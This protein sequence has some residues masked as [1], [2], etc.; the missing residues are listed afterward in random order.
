MDTI[1]A[2]VALFHI[3][4]HP[5]ALILYGVLGVFLLTVGVFKEL[6]RDQKKLRLIRLFDYTVAVSAIPGTIVAGW[7]L[8]SKFGLII[9]IPASMFSVLGVLIFYHSCLRKWFGIDKIVEDLDG[10]KTRAGNYKLFKAEGG[11]PGAWRDVERFL[12]TTERSIKED[13]KND[14]SLDEVFGKANNQPETGLVFSHTLVRLS[15]MDAV[16]DSD[17]GDLIDL[18]SSSIQNRVLPIKELLDLLGDERKVKQIFNPSSA[19]LVLLSANSLDRE[20]KA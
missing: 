14:P 18:L 19:Q 17:W 15:L 9:G 5:A 16:S 12:R 1:G 4:T 11:S 13:Y 10:V 6:Q 20:R 3:L 7:I 2:L 8:I